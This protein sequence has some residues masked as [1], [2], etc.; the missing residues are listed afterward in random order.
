LHQM[1]EGG[2]VRKLGADVR[3]ASDR[4][5]WRAGC[6]CNDAADVELLE[7]RTHRRQLRGAQFLAAQLKRDDQAEVEIVGAALAHL[8]CQID[9][10][11]DACTVVDM[12][13][14]IVQ[15]I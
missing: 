8:R 9:R 5:R 6:L 14:A 7:A 3:G 10:K 1:G 4:G 11:R 13:T 15:S 2:V 12:S